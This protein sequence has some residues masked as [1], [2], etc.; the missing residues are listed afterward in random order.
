MSS[1]F[2]VQVGLSQ[3]PGAPLAWL[4]AR[5]AGLAGAVQGAAA[6]LA[7]GVTL[8]EAEARAALARHRGAVW[9]AVTECVDTLRRQVTNKG[10]FFFW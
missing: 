2:Q 5:W 4:R 7:P 1:L 10:F 9:P 3:S 6:R 8:S